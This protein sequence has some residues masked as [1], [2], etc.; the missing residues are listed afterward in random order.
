MAGDCGRDVA[1][2]DAPDDM[3]E[4][5]LAVELAGENS[6]LRCDEDDTVD[7]SRKHCVT[8]LSSGA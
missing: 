8:R 7:A 1:G 5:E 4:N 6:V 2:D 3:V